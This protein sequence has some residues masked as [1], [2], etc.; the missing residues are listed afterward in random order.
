MK[1]AYRVLIQPSAR[2]ELRSLPDAVLGKATQLILN[3]AA[4]PRPA[5]CRK[6]VTSRAKYRVR[7]GDYRIVYSVDDAAKSATVLRVR[8]RSDTYT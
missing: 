6:L 7:A 2:K 5:G 4:N 8:H 1:D 3:L